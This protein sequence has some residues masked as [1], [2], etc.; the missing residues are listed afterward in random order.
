M[1]T[2]T[3]VLLVVVVG[4]GAIAYGLYKKEQAKKI[5]PPSDRNNDNSRNNSNS[6]DVQNYVAAGTD[7]LDSIGKIFGGH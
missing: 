1:K 5:A 6:N 3:I 2:Q 4:A 7:V